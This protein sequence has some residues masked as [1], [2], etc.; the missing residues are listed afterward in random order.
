[1]VNYEQGKIY[2]IEFDENLYIG[3]TSSPRLSSRRSKHM[4][5]TKHNMTMLLYKAIRARQTK[6]DGI[7][8]ILVENYPCKSSDELRA[9][10]RYWIEQLRP[11]LNVMNPFSSD[12]EKKE[13]RQSFVKVYYKKPEV[14]EMIK[15]HQKTYKAKPESKEKIKE[16]KKQ[17]NA[18]NK[19]KVKE[20]KTLWR[21]KVVKCPHCDVQLKRGSLNEHIKRRHSDKTEGADEF[22]Q[23]RREYESVRVECPSCNI[24]ISRNA[25][26]THKKRFHSTS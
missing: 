1:M 9:R 18:D 13:K 23:K 6:W 25:L 16:T 5:F 4:D 7:H 20:T 22:L 17:Y 12:E 2:K 3:S 24:D 21:T 10:E 26:R 14:K 19:D 11:N 8:C 15:V